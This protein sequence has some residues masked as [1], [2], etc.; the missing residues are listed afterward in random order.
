MDSSTFEL[1]NSSNCEFNDNYQECAA[2]M[3]TKQFMGNRI[4]EQQAEIDKL[5]SQLFY[6]ALKNNQYLD[7]IKHLELQLKKLS[8]FT[9][10]TQV[11]VKAKKLLL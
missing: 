8:K 6:Q 7:W 10:L 3:K 1:N 2:Y 11:R 5:K 4:F 9:E